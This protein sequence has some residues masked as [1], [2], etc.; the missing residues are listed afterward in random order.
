MRNTKITQLSYYKFLNLPSNSFN[1]ELLMNELAE[2]D[3]TIKTTPAGRH[4][5][6][7]GHRTSLLT[8]ELYTL[9]DSINC[10]VLEAEVFY[11]AP[12]SILPWHIDMNPPADNT[13]LNFVWGNANHKMRFGEI[14]DYSTLST[15]S[16]T[17]AGSQYV[18]FNDSQVI[19][20]EIVCLYKPALINSGRPHNIVNWSPEGRWCLSVI[21]THNNNRI[22]FDDAVKMFSEYVLD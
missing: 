2:Y 3:L 12:F 5:R 21:L 8:N 20:K 4:W 16:T 13:K 19:P 10:D 7:W 18:E 22:L 11:T 9:L 6:N 14:A 17:Q 1:K 15:T